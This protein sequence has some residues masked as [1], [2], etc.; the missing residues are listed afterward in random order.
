[1]LPRVRGVFLQIVALSLTLFAWSNDVLHI[2]HLGADETLAQHD[3]STGNE[4]P[5]TT[6]TDGLTDEVALAP[7]RI[8]VRPVLRGSLAPAR[9]DASREGEDHSRIPTRPPRW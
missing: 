2:M 9:Q 4:E 1:M 8:S 3:A 6:R 7:D 5:D